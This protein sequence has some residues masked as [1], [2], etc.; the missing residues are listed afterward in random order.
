MGEPTPRIPC[1][2]WEPFN[3]AGHEYRRG[4]QKVHCPGR[5]RPGMPWVSAKSSRSSERA[6]VIAAWHEKGEA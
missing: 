2:L 5:N 1:H 6:A 3:H 4:D